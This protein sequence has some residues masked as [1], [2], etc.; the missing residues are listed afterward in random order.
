MRASFKTFFGLSWLT[1]QLCTAQTTLHFN[2][3]GPERGLTDARVECIYQ[4]SRG[5][6]WLGTENGLNRFDGINIKTYSPDP[7][8]PEL[9]HPQVINQIQE[10][11]NGNLL[12]SGYY[13]IYRYQPEMDRFE[14]LF[15]PKLGGETVIY[16]QC[17]LQDS[18]GKLWFG[19]LKHGLM[20]YNTRSQQLDF[21]SEETGRKL[22]PGYVIEMAEDSFGQFWFSY[23]NGIYQFDKESQAL[24]YH[25]FREDLE[26]TRNEKMITAIVEDGKRNLWVGTKEGIWQFDRSAQQFIRSALTPESGGRPIPIGTLCPGPHG[27][28]WI[29][30]LQ[31]LYILDITGNKL[32]HHPAERTKEGGIKSNLINNI[33]RSPTGDMWIATYDQGVFHYSL[34]RKP[35]GAVTDLRREYQ[36]IPTILFEKTTGQTYLADRNSVALW[37]PFTDAR[38]AAEMSYSFLAAMDFNNDIWIGSWEHGLRRFDRKNKL[39]AAYGSNTDATGLPGISATKLLCDRAGTIWVGIWLEGLYRY[40]PQT[41]KFVPFEL[42]DPEDGIH[43]RDYNVLDLKESPNGGIWIATEDRLIKLGSD[44][45]VERIIGDLPP[46]YQIYETPDSNTLWLA[47]QEGL[48]RWNADTEQINFWR[49]SDGLPDNVVH[50]VQ[51]DDQGNLWIG[52][53]KGL[54]KFNPRDHTF[55]NFGTNDGLPGSTFIRGESLKARN[56]A[57]Y[58]G[59]NGGIL[60]FFPDSIRKSK[61]LPNVV[62]TDLKIAG[63]PTAIRPVGDHT[64]SDSFYLPRDVPFID[65]LRLAWQQ[66]DFSFEFITL[67]YYQPEKTKY[68]YRLKNYDDQWLETGAER[69]YANYTNLNPGKYSFQVMGS[70]SDGIFNEKVASVDIIIAPPWWQ[71]WWAVSLSILFI[72]LAIAAYVR[73]RLYRLQKQ[74]KVLEQT[75]KERTAEMKTQ[76]EIAVQERK[77]SEELLLN[78]LPAK[79]AQELKQYGSSPARNYEQ[80]TVLF[81]D[82][83]QFTVISEKLSA[84]ELV[85]EINN[86][87]KQFDQI[88]TKYRVE[89]IKTIGDAY[90]AATGLGLEPDEK[91]I[92]I[93]W[94]ALEMQEYIEQRKQ[95]REAAGMPGFE[96]RCGIHTGPVVAGIVG[97]KKFQYDIWGDTVNVAARMESNGEVGKV[98]I[99]AATHQLLKDQTGLTFLPRGEI[100]VRNK[101]GMDMFFV[102]KS[103]TPLPS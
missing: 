83:K 43:I 16:P 19:T 10:D 44:R 72:L 84:E 101:G 46:C 85:S 13:G 23:P 68:R 7:N 42:I 11:G 95:I 99:S 94:A 28:L 96:M 26:R 58:F 88:V 38:P 54:S 55:L 47:T 103:P 48:G 51:G 32:T 5:Y 2:Q 91:V 71:T 45:K 90:M 98:N 34:E 24:D 66:R 20:S 8:R 59:T 4:D 97:I 12:L 92:D 37:S 56:G 87:F 62:I 27:N 31:G 82:F 41:D 89:K 15:E 29:G 81:T 65:E 73:W 63:Q 102:Q 21:F 25:P 36:E 67:N 60:H 79:V 3:I 64:S 78:V 53:L 86:C 57:L 80:V 49:A 35:F 6:M 33:Y 39:V 17:I 22:R 50:S 76:K 9:N 69:P 18:T 30:T 74:Q 40:L 61:N 93:V 1:V 14:L 100:M 75:V 77:R 70:N 52:T